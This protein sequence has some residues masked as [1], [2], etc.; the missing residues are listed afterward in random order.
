MTTIKKLKVDWNAHTYGSASVLSKL[1]AWE[2]AVY[3]RGDAVDAYGDAVDAY[4]DAVDAY[5]DAFQDE[6]KKS[7]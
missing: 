1:A 7:K 3:T 5:G 6:L 2:A 4:G